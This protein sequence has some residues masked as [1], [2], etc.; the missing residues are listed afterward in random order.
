[1]GAAVALKRRLFRIPGAVLLFFALMLFPLLLGLGWLEY[2]ELVT[3]K[4]GIRI[5]GRYL[6][7][8][9]PIT[10]VAVA[11]ALT[12]LRDRARELAAGLVIGGMAVLQVLSLAMVAGRF[13]A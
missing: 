6:L 9:M 12:L 3:L 4:Y 5:Q 1:M 2:R 8:L 13:Y 10:G 7:G 11:A